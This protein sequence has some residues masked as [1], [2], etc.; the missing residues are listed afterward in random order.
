MSSNDASAPPGRRRLGGTLV[1]DR[2]SDGEAV[3]LMRLAPGEDGSFSALFERTEVIGAVHIVKNAAGTWTYDK[4]AAPVLL[5]GEGKVLQPLPGAALP[6]DAG[7]VI[8]RLKSRL[9]AKQGGAVQ[10]GAVENMDF[11]A[12]EKGEAGRWFVGYAGK[13]YPLEAPAPGDSAP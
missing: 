8:A 11:F 7:S 12:F 10:A 5:N 9:G 6:Q 1:T 4:D 3:M 2:R 13:V